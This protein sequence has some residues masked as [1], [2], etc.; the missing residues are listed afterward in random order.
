MCASVEWMD[1]YDCERNNTKIRIQRETLSTV[2]FIFRIKKGKK[3]GFEVYSKEIITVNLIF[4]LSWI[5]KE[6]KS[7][8]KGEK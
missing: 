7:T 1:S 2:F 3:G 8:K 5:I 4:F 6:T